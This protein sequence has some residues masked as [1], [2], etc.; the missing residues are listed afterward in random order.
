[1]TTLRAVRLAV[2]PEA[3][4]ERALTEVGPLLRRRVEVGAPD[5]AFVARTRGSRPA[6]RRSPTLSRRLPWL[7]PP[8]HVAA[9]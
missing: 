7:F 1:M 5:P 4:L 6:R 3:T 9:V 8:R 2:A